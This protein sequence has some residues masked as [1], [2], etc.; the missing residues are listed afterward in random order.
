MQTNPEIELKYY[1]IVKSIDSALILAC[2]L[3]A[4]VK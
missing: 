3:L 1:K 4:S 2:S